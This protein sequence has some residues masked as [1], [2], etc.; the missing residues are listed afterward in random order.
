MCRRVIKFVYCYQRSFFIGNISL[1][2]IYFKYKEEKFISPY[3]TVA[4]GEKVK[5]YLR[6]GAKPIRG[7]REYPNEKVGYGALCVENSLPM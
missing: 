2:A 7:E 6:R 3:L 5:A 1:I 4:Y